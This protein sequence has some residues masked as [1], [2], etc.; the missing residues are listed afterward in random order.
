MRG[1]FR[2]TSFLAIA[3]VVVSWLDAFG[4]YGHSDRANLC[5][6]PCSLT[7]P[8][9]ARRDLSAFAHAL[10]LYNHCYPRPRAAVSDSNTFAVCRRRRSLCLMRPS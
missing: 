10:L 7:G 3:H 8:F 5:L 2:E 4:M 1:D 6:V 9:T